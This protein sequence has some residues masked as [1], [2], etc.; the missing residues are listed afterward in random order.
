ML[1]RANF[2]AKAQR[3]SINYIEIL[4]RDQSRRQGFLQLT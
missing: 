4:P 3:T 2:T 1:Q